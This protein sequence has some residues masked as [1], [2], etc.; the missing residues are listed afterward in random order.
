MNWL[1]NHDVSP[2]TRNGMFASDLVPNRSLRA[3]IDDYLHAAVEF[4]SSPSKAESKAEDAKEVRN[5]PVAVFE[6]PRMCLIGG[7]AA[8]DCT[9]EHSYMLSVESDNPAL[10]RRHP[11]TIVCVVDTSGSM[12]SEAK[13]QGVE[14]RGLS[15][16]DIVKHAVRTT[17]TTLED[18]DRFGLVKFSTSGSIV[19]DLMYM[20]AAGKALALSHVNDLKTGGSTN[21]WDGLKLGMDLLVGA[22]ETAGNSAL[23]LLTDGGIINIYHSKC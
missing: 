9:T 4:S 14:S 2:I 3:S 15:L 18:H 22:G 19:C 5:E 10:L 23:F 11:A 8:L 13:V 1:E 12:C 7:N 6:S 21:L 20:T 17:I 16:L